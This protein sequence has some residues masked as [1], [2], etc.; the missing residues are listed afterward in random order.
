MKELAMKLKSNLDFTSHIKMLRKAMGIGK[1]HFFKCPNGHLFVIG[2]CGGA[3]EEA[4][5]NE[6]G[7]KIGG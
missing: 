3:M 1:G 2:E 4:K 5:C 7:A 6:C